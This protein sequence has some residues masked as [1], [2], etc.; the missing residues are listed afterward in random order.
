MENQYY[1][2]YF[3]LERSHWWFLVRKQI[4]RERLLGMLPPDRPLQ[5]LNIGASTCATSEM[6]AEFGNVVSVEY[7]P[8]CVEYTRSRLEIELE[9]GSIL[10]LRF[11]NHSFDLV[12]AFDVIEHVEDDGRAV[13]EMKRVCKP[14]GIV[15]VTVPAFRFLWSHHDVVNHHYR[16]YTMSQLRALFIMNSSDAHANDG[17]QIYHSYFNTLLFPPVAAF[18][19][20]S[21]LIP[22]NLIRKG[23][24][25]DNNILPS[26]SPVNKL[27]KGLFGLERPILK[28]GV[29]FPFGV[30]AMLCWRAGT[31]DDA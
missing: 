23:S 16:R 1:K 12:C 8:F 14:C 28:A 26:D 6:L 13:S 3:E 31:T 30:S 20:L 22:S 25:V 2:E 27:L 11:A 29:R 5:I 9:Q 19:L 4:L 17:R 21:G 15:A 24:G 7:D 10:E 18:R